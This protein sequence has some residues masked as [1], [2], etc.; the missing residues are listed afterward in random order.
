MRIKKSFIFT[1]LVLILVG[2]IAFVEKKEGERR[3]AEIDVYVRSIAD[4]Y[5]VE[6]KEILK[7]VK[8]EFPL[9]ETGVAL[10]EVDLQQIERKVEKHPFVKNAEVYGDLKG[11]VR[12]EVEQH[13]PIARIVRPMAAD[14]YITSE[15]LILPTSPNYTSRVLILEGAYAERLLALEN[16]KDA[17]PE[18][19]TLIEF[20]Q[21]DEFWKAQI[22]ELEIQRKGDIKLHQ[23]VGRQVIEFG[24][25][26]DI[27]EKFRKI[28]LFYEKILPAQG[29]NTYHRV[30]V[31][32][33][34]QIVCE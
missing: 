3:L 22:T 34:D 2:F 1:V 6:E 7:A 18:L 17:E 26:S 13:Q 25:A 23:Q 31:K 10:H 24:D 14:G 9:L 32:Y 19:L 21:N 12:I 8:T 29:W 20:I 27:A 28:S 15:G 30:N 5:F 16:L 4:V 33:K 11:N